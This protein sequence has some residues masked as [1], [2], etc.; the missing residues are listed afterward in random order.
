MDYWCGLKELDE[1]PHY[2]GW[3]GVTLFRF[4]KPDPPPGYYWCD[5]QFLT[6]KRTYKG[7]A[8]PRDVRPKDWPAKDGP[9]QRDIIKA[10][11]EYERLENEALALRNFP[12]IPPDVAVPAMITADGRKVTGRLAMENSLSHPGFDKLSSVLKDFLMKP[13]SLPSRNTIGNSDLLLRQ[14]REIQFGTH[15]N[16]IGKKT[17]TI[18]GRDVLLPLKK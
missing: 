10:Y 15:H 16:P 7:A 9:K 3:R 6:Q 5:G 8:K 4:V 18:F 17:S 14:C 12:R 11:A 1:V 2:K 13:K